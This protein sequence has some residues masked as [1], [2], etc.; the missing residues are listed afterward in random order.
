MQKSTVL[1]TLLLRNFRNYTE[2]TLSFS[3]KK[4]LIFGENAQGKT[5][6][7]EALSLITTGRSHRTPYLSECIQHNKPYF[8]LEAHFSIEDLEMVIKLYYDKAKRSLSIDGKSYNTF[9][10]LIGL[11]PSV[12]HT[13]NDLLLISSTPSLRRRLFDLHISSHDK[14]YLNQ[15][16]RYYRAKKQRDQLLKTKV[17]DAIE[18]FEEEMAKCS[19]ILY[20]KRKQMTQELQPLFSSYAQKLILDKNLK[21]S[22]LP[23]T[24]NILLELLKKNRPKEFILGN[25]LQGPHRDDFTFSIEDK[26]AKSFAS[27]GQKRACVLSLRLAEYQRL[28]NHNSTILFCIDDMATHFDPERQKS[29]KEVIRDLDQV[30]I[31]LPDPNTKLDIADKTFFVKEGFIHDC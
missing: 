21:I 23:S 6:L 1:Q 18:C 26:L 3:P 16:I 4:N 30:F 13:P 5:N 22:Y 28:K 10:P 19:D 29:L 15:L 25:T 12:I 8:Y 7:I 11:H 27:E 9:S 24:E 20:N 31:T 14:E 2:Q 17:V